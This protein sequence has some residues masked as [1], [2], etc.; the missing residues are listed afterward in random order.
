MYSIHVIMHFSSVGISVE[1]V[2]K[3]FQYTAKAVP[4][5]LLLIPYICWGYNLPDNWLVV[6]VKQVFRVFRLPCVTKSP[7][8]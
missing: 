2:W 5:E 3:G 8:G 7:W 6:L 4:T 1:S